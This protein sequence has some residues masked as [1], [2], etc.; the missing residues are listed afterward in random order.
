MVAT[1]TQQI[2][3]LRTREEFLQIRDDWQSLWSETR[4]GIYC[5]WD[6]LASVFDAYGDDVSHCHV[7]I[8]RGGRLTTILPAS[9]RG[10]ELLS[11]GVP[12]ADSTDFMCIDANPTES[13]IAC[14]NTLVTEVPEWQTTCFDLVPADSPLLRAA[15]ASDEK[16]DSSYRTARQGPGRPLAAFRAVAPYRMLQ[17]DTETLVR[18]VAWKKTPRRRRNQLR[19]LGDLQFERLTDVEH[20][21][22]VLPRFIEMHQSRRESLGD[23]S[24]LANTNGAVFISQL[25]DRLGPDGLIT[26]HTLS[27]DHCV[28]ACCCGFEAHGRYYYYTPTFDSKWGQ[29]GVGSVLLSSILED[30]VR[31]GVQ[32]FDFGQGDEDYKQRFADASDSLYAVHLFR[33]GFRS[34]VSR[35]Q[36]ALQEKLRQHPALY[37]QLKKL[38]GQ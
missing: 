34:T 11:P 18:E 30:C 24:F 32:I 12:R 29:Y 26:W 1:S 20:M 5:H 23:Q 17:G 15:I 38:A 14:L 6:W 35:L 10:T 8:R 21:H 7:A 9:L 22:R 13:A 36:I 37:Q 3:L 16:H 27:L 31:R 19:K 28:I 33:N 2:S 25:T 4:S